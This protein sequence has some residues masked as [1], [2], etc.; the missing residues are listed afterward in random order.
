MLGQYRGIQ[1]TWIWENANYYKWWSDLVFMA[2]YDTDHPTL[3]YGELVATR[4][5]LIHRWNTTPQIVKTFIAKLLRDKMISVRFLDRKSVYK[6][7]EFYNPKITRNQPENNPKATRL[8]DC[9]TDDYKGEQPEINPKITRNQSENNPYI[10]NIN[11]NINK[12]IYIYPPISPQGGMSAQPTAGS[13]NTHQE[14]ELEL[15]FSSAETQQKKEKKVAQKKENIFDWERFKDFFN[16]TMEGS[17]IRKINVMN[18][19]RKDAVMARYREMERDY[20]GHGKEKIIYA[21]KIV[22]TDEYC[23]GLCNGWIATFDDIFT[24]K[25]FRRL[26]EGGYQ[27]AKQPQQTYHGIQTS[28]KQSAYDVFLKNFGGIDNGTDFNDANEQTDTNAAEY[29]AAEIVG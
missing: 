2:N 17:N 27:R 10:L 20:K 14:M 8:P 29:V 19:E 6:I 28:T 26:V 5:M 11:K 13:E 1:K 12:D 22:A 18:K 4:T 21:L 24:R 25:I 23:N 9:N 16:A 15:P 3:Q 7:N